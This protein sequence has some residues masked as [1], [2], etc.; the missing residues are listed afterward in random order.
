MPAGE[1][2][3]F[4][5]LEWQEALSM[6]INELG[7]MFSSSCFLSHFFKTDMVHFLMIITVFFYWLASIRYSPIFWPSMEND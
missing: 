5:H 7:G 4:C 6:T 1:G 2:N 3:A